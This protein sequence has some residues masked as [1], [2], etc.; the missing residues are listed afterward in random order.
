MASM[1]C[2]QCT[3]G[4]NVVEFP[5]VADFVAHTQGGHVS[6]PKKV[7]PPPAK[8]VEPSATE[9]KAQQEALEKASN[10]PTTQQGLP[11]STPVALPV[12]PLVLEYKWVGVH[13]IC[14]SEVRTIGVEVNDKDMAVVAF[15]FNCNEQLAQQTVV[16]IPQLEEKKEVA[17]RS[18]K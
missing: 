3:S 14:N 6:R 7:A 17:S 10:A 15:C 13:A 4:D 5:S 9:L 2:I 1:L 16:K 11:S 8:P 12:K 18:K